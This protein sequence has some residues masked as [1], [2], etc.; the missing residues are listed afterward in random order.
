MNLRR[1]KKFEDAKERLYNNMA[2]HL[3]FDIDHKWLMQFENINKV[4]VLNKCIS[5]R[6]KRWRMNTEWYKEYLLKFYYDEQ[7]NL[8]YVKW[9]ES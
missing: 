4:K 1:K 6:D 5:M 3:R 8:I 2:K 7:F 9:I